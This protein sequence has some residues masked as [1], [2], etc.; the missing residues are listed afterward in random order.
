MSFT[1]LIGDVKKSPTFWGGVGNY[2]GNDT[3]FGRG[4]NDVGNLWNSAMGNPKSQLIGSPATNSS[5]SDDSQTMQPVSR[6]DALNSY[7]IKYPSQQSNTSQQMPVSSQPSIQQRIGDSSF[8]MVPIAQL[9]DP[10][11]K[12]GGGAADALKLAKLFAA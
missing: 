3:G 6:Q 8:N 4:I 10:S 5:S 12:S 2:I 9:P 7:N 1:D 11:G